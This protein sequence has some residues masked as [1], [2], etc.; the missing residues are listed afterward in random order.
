MGF[1]RRFFS[2]P[3]ETPPP[4]AAR[5]AILEQEIKSLRLEWNETYDKIAHQFDRLRKRQKAALEAPEPE[6]GNG[7]LLTPEAVWDHARRRGIV[8]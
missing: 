4:L 6:A 2:V 5:I 3:E 7:S 1:L 8:G